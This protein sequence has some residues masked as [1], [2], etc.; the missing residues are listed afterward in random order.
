M[1]VH[2]VIAVVVV[3]G[4]LA[5]GAATKAPALPGLLTT[6]APWPAN[7]RAPLRARLKAAGIPAL[8]AEGSRLHT[9]QHLDIV[10]D[11]SGYP[12]PA[13]IGIDPRNRFIA[14]L[15]THDFS[16]HQSHRVADRTD[17]HARAALRRVGSPLLVE[18]PRRLLHEG[19]AATRCSSTGKRC[20]AI[21]A[22]SC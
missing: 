17:V 14:P 10:I 16:R 6:K 22:R 19:E 21:R 1:R 15:H 8:G 4:V 11:G 20:S 13:G 12:V 3:A 2:S 9:H 7:N 5:G 18:L